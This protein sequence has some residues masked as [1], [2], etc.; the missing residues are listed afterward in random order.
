MN[1]KEMDFIL[2]EG[3]RQFIMNQNEAINF[4]EE[5]ISLNPNMPKIESSEHSIGIGR[6]VYYVIK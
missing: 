2:Q 1:Q 5:R 3:E 4:S 6:G